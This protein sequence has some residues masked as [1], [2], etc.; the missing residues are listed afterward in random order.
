MERARECESLKCQVSDLTRHIERLNSDNLTVKARLNEALAD[1][2]SLRITSHDTLRQQIDKLNDIH[3][4]NKTIACRVITDDLERNHAHA[5]NRLQESLKAELEAC[6]ESHL[7]KEATMKHEIERL[8]SEL[9]VIRQ[10]K[11]VAADAIKI[12]LQQ[13][14]EHEKSIIL[15]EA[16]EERE[17]QVNIYKQQVNDITCQLEALKVCTCF[18]KYVSTSSR[19]FLFRRYNCNR[20]YRKMNAMLARVRSI[21]IDQV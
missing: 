8:R 21:A 20:R 11:A 15:M 14:F 7:V 3:M 19:Y 2:V 5:M 1:L 12:E 13:N 6:T 9:K 16:A 18:K 17:A 10:D 4:E